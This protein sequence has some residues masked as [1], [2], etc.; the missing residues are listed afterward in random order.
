[1]LYCKALKRRRAG[2]VLRTGR[3]RIRAG[4]S[5]CATTIVGIYAVLQCLACT[6][7]YAMAG[8]LESWCEVLSTNVP[9]LFSA[10]HTVFSLLSTVPCAGQKSSAQKTTAPVARSSP[11]QLLLF[12]FF[13]AEKRQRSA[14]RCGKVSFSHEKYHSHGS[15][16]QRYRNFHQQKKTFRTVT[17][18]VNASTRRRD[19]SG[20]QITKLSRP[21]GL[22]VFVYHTHLE[23]LEE[24]NAE[25]FT[26][27]NERNAAGRDLGVAVK[28]NGIRSEK[29]VDHSPEEKRKEVE[30]I[31]EQQK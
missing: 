8:R 5:G 2:R 28:T 3:A 29:L 7:S 10:L 23:G 31:E 20:N 16:F 9:Y 21:A 13:S 19:I 27:R 30:S 4:S 17:V 18:L 24:K 14:H 6:P 12:T 1:M 26:C 22:E 11:I 15:A 25:T